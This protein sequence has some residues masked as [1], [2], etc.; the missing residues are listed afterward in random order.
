MAH[1]KREEKGNWEQLFPCDKKKVENKTSVVM[2]QGKKQTPKRKNQ[3][4]GENAQV[5]ENWQQGQK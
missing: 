1:S 4:K 3:E 5:G 2:Y